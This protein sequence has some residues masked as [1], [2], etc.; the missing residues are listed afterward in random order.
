VTDSASKDALI[1]TLLDRRY[2]I[3]RR[4]A[5]GG[6]STVYLATD[7]KLRRQVA[8]KVLYPH[9]AE[10]PAFVERFE[11]EAITA[12]KF[13]HPHVVSVY[14]QGVDAD[15]A[16]LVMEYVP[17]ATLR[18]IMSAQG[19]FSP[20][21]ALQVIDAVL[22]GLSAAHRAGLVHRDV[23]PENVLISPDGRI[24]VADFGLA[25]A[26]TKHTST[27]A[28]IGTVAYVS[29]ELVMGKP[30]DTRADLYAVGV[31]LHELLTGKQ[32]YTGDTAWAVAL[33]HVNEEIPPASASVPGLSTELDELI[34]WCTEKDPEDRPHDAEALLQELRHARSQLSEEQLD[35]G[36]A[37]APL[38]TLL[39]STLALMHRTGERPGGRDDAGQAGPYPAPDA[40]SAGSQ[41][42]SASGASPAPAGAGFP[43]DGGS[44]HASLPD[45][46]D[47]AAAPEWL[48]PDWAGPGSDASSASTQALSADAWG[49]ASPGSDAGEAATQAL[50]HGSLGAAGAAA[51]AGVTAAGAATPAPAQDPTQVLPAQPDPTAVLG[52]ASSGGG[53]AGTAGAPGGQ[54]P[55]EATS[56][57]APQGA[58]RPL[59]PTAWPPAGEPATPQ[60]SAQQVVPRLAPALE[61]EVQA[62]VAYP[63]RPSKRRAKAEAKARA[64]AAQEPTE[65]LKRPGTGKKAWIWAALLLIVA[66]LVG[67]AAWFFG[68]GPGAR[69]LIPELRGATESAARASLDEQGI[70]TI[71]VATAF[72]EEVEQGK[73]VSTDPPGGSQIMRLSS[74]TLLIS[75]GP[76]L[77]AVPNV[78]GQS[79]A[80][81]KQ[82][83]EE[84]HLAL[85]KVTQAYDESI[86]KGLVVS[87]AK[88]VGE[89][90]RS[91]TKV[92]LVISRGQAPVEVPSLTGKSPE[93][94]EQLLAAQSLKPQRGDDVF[95]DDVAEG[96]VAKQAPAAG[97]KVSKGSTIE[98]QVSKGPELFEVPSVI[99]KSTDD[100]RALLEDAGFS[101]DVK[102]GGVFGT[103]FDRV[104]GQD[105][106]SGTMATKGSTVTITVY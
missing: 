28:L 23:K 100:A 54:A 76:Q 4:L 20:R 84:Q 99:N 88:K 39:T 55:A 72:D 33:A 31:L 106:R 29:P 71:N 102:S 97:E 25:R 61:P 64:K 47:D 34:A 46:E 74:V 66:A 37:P 41:P 17:G 53:T 35:L 58:T 5:R 68:A 3:E 101:V 43:A 38:A 80:A 1:G 50:P 11:A 96:R 12:A 6:M 13:S 62:E 21:A 81:A 30:A 52:P 67:T 56:V 91:D 59:E 42:G 40:A 85:G 95:S 93:D 8:V 32:P 87:Q 44:G 36:E 77:Y 14:D 89:Q 27:G 57:L 65:S 104:V 45:D 75:K 92:D 60:P 2:L 51:A 15:T 70:S 19:R 82:A 83:L 24:K 73:V 90:L 49:A 10:D 94:A 103:V 16:Y 7:Q 18:D 9:L 78:V 63:E 79:Q 48:S 98:Y 86:D 69:V 26:A 22:G 105:P